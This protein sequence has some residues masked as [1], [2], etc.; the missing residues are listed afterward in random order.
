M[1]RIIYLQRQQLRDLNFSNSEFQEGFAFSRDNDSVFHA[2]TEFPKEGFCGKAVPCFFKKTY[3]D[4]KKSD[5]Q[6][7]LQE[8][9]PNNSDQILLILIDEN[10]Q[11][12]IQG[13]FKS[14]NEWFSCEINFLPESDELFSRNKGLLENDV[15]QK[16][17]VGIVGVGSG[18]SAIALELAKAGV[19]N[20]ILIDYDRLG[21]E[22]ISRH[23]CGINDLGRFKTFAVRDALMQK[24]PAAKIHTHEID[25][26]LKR[27]QCEQAL[28]KCDILI[29]ASDNDRSRFL[30]NEI[31]LKNKVPA[32]FGRALTRAIGGDVLRVRPYEGPCYSCLY[33]QNVRAAGGD[34]EEISQPKQAKKLLPAYTSEEDFHAAVQVG[35]SADIAP[36]SN[37]IVKLALSELTKNTNA[38]TASL[39]DDF[40]ADFYLW[41]NRRENIYETWQKLGVHF[42]QPTI[43]RWYG[44]KVE[45]DLN[46]MVCGD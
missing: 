9:I 37:F 21:P 33:S 43:L 14:G 32:I 22:N 20:F 34:D 36:I 13:F 40:T 23:I 2:F 19:G 39:A 10:D 16:K 44:A 45:R 8:D 24:N 5:A 27:E 29:G 17:S 25:I 41:A 11:Q 26:V 31:A 18:G 30:L 3:G 35:L 15:L 46:C 6:K 28:Q 7:I 4:Q 12:G 38:A 1:E 42:N